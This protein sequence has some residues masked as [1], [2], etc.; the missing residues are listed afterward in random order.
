VPPHCRSDAS[1]SPQHQHASAAA[2][3][4]ERSGSSG[5]GDPVWGAA[6]GVA[7]HELRQLGGG[8]RGFAAASAGQA[9]QQ[10][11]S[12]SSSASRR[13]GNSASPEALYGLPVTSQVSRSVCHADNQLAEI[14][15]KVV[16]AD[17]LDLGT[18]PA[19]HS[20][21]AFAV[22]PYLGRF[23]ALVG[24]Q[25]QPEFVKAVVPKQRQLECISR[26][27]FALTWDP[28]VGG[29]PTLRTLSGNSLI[30]DGRAVSPEELVQV[31]DGSN[32]SFSGIGD[33]DPQFLILR[34]RLRPRGAVASD[35]PHPALQVSVPKA[36][37]CGAGLSAGSSP[38]R[39]PSAGRQQKQEHTLLAA[40]LE[41]VHAQGGRPAEVAS[42]ARSIMLPIDE[43]LEIGRQHQPG[44]FEELLRA[45]PQWLTYISRAHCRIMLHASG[46]GG[47]SP[48]LLLRVE[49]LSANAVLVCGKPLAKGQV[50]T[51]AEGGTLEFVAKQRESLQDTKFLSFMLR[52]V[53]PRPLPAVQL[54]C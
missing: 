7:Q 12:R 38:A 19:S 13:P 1:A 3:I 46:S 16:R 11:H 31:S 6:R 53:S 36:G 48:Q 10:Q 20:A 33:A 44:S 14:V 29:N 17:G 2:S 43:P 5:A 37:D 21:I 15:L 8:P 24:R 30:I 50:E 23:A 27:H 34:A 39:L 28:A 41:C 9:P 18:V 52:R 25:H 26:A 49:N 40:S 51:I 22:D 4:V 45:E 54:P 35:G 47:P 42:E 32:L